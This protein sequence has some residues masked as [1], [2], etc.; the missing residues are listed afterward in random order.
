MTKLTFRS[1][2]ELRKLA[3]ETLSNSKFKIPYQE[4]HTSEKGFWLVKD[5]GVYLMNSFKRNP[6][7]LI[8]YA[9]GYKPTK[10]NR[11]SLWNKT[12]KVSPDDFAEFIPLNSQQL[13]RLSKNGYVTIH[14]SA[15]ELTVEA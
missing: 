13:E 9:V 4:K 7:N 5:E 10:A 14:L 6:K 1:S 8:S 2:K 11:D 12:H 15:T 3:E